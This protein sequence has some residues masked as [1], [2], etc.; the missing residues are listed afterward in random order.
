MQRAIKVPRGAIDVDIERIKARPA[1]V[2]R[3]RHHVLRMPEQPLDRRGGQRI[4]RPLPMDLRPPQG[5][6]GIDIA[7]P[8]DHPLVQQDPLDAAGLGLD[9][10]RRRPGVIRR[11]KRV[12]P[13]VR[14]LLRY[15]ARVQAR[16]ARTP[17][18]R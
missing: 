10:P 11:V 16:R 5:L 9:R 15:A 14:D 12:R 13:D 4:R 3:R 17:K 8:R 18:V 7:D 6:I 1:L 2:Q